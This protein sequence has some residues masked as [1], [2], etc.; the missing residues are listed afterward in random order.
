M[1]PQTGWVFLWPHLIV[2]ALALLVSVATL[3]VMSR[4]YKA[5]RS[6]LKKLSE[7][8]AVVELSYK[9]IAGF[10]KD[11]RRYLA[12]DNEEEGD[13]WNTGLS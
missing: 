11:M 5:S 7:F 13:A 10:R 9:E 6:D 1:E 2:S 3:V 4:F 8:Y 12:R